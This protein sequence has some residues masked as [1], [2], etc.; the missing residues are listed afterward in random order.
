MT[1]FIPHV[2]YGQLSN[3]GDLAG[4]SALVVV[5][6]QAHSRWFSEKTYEK[7]PEADRE[8]V[9]VPGARHI[10]LYDDE[11]KIPFDKLDEFF[12]TNLS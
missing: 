5:G 6:D 7:L 8:L 2:A 10:D 12:T 9:I 3:L 4:R 1:S 11:S